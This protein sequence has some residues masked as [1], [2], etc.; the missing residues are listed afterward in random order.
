MSIFRSV[1]RGFG[2]GLG[3]AAARSVVRSM[4]QQKP[5]KQKNNHIHA[6][7]MSAHEYKKVHQNEKIYFLPLQRHYEY[8]VQKDGIRFFIIFIIPII[9]FMLSMLVLGFVPALFIALF[10]AVLAYTFS[11]K[12]PKR[13]DITSPEQERAHRTAHANAQNWLDIFENNMDLMK[14][15]SDPDIYFSRVDET[16]E[17]AIVLASAINHKHISLSNNL[18]NAIL[19]I[20]ENKLCLTRDFLLKNYSN[21][22]KNIES[23]KTNKT[24]I[25]KLTN[26]V[27]SV[28]TYASQFN[29]DNLKIYL[30]QEKECNMLIAK[31][32]EERSRFFNFY[33]V[34]LFSNNRII[35]AS[36]FPLWDMAFF[37]SLVI[38][39]V[40][41]LSSG[42]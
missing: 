27:N 16:N 9:T 21:L 30:R 8:E 23:L 37:S 22:I 33:Q 1:A 31:W 13:I 5:S 40:V 39:A 17:V 26:Y 6:P 34:F 18:T 42:T 32:L 36:A 28:S 2:W 41:L 38:C 35:S 14:K 20:S 7:S 24:K 12:E 25:M 4:S 15:T 29:D 19:D 10:V 11:K 3:S